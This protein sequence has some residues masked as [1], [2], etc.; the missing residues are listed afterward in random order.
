MNALIFESTGQI[1]KI[2]FAIDF[3][4]L[5]EGFKLYKITL[6]PLRADLKE[7]ESKAKKQGGRP[8][9]LGQPEPNVTEEKVPSA[10]AQ[11]FQPCGFLRWVTVFVFLIDRCL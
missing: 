11:T 1:G 4:M 2:L 9:P 7:G 8:K 5:E 3:L 10:A 6:R